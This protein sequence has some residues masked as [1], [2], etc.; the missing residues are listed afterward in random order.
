MLRLALSLAV[1]A[2]A[3]TCARGDDG[4]KL[5]PLSTARGGVCLDGTPGAICFRPG[6]NANA[7]KWMVHLQGGGWCNSLTGCLERSK[8]VLGSSST[9]ASQVRC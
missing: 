5:I 6:R 4:F 1:L 8:T 3:S 9:W 2:L 7:T